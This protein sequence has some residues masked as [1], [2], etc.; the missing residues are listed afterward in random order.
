MN[1]RHGL[2][3]RSFQWVCA[4][5]HGACGADDLATL[6][7]KHTGDLG[8]NAPAC[9][10]HDGDFAVEFPHAC[11]LARVCLRPLRLAFTVA[12]S[13]ALATAHSQPAW[14]SLYASCYRA[15]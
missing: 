12:S 4:L 15:S 3:Q 5:L 13:N 10:S 14:G 7:R 6:C 8:A 2:L 1:V 9:S 11:L